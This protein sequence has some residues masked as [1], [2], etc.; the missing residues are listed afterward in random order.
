MPR[1][2]K[3]VPSYRLHKTSGQAVVTVYRPDGTPRDLLLGPFE[4]AASRAEYARVCAAL[5]PGSVYVEP[6]AETT[7]AEVILAF[8][9]HAQEYYSEGDEFRTFR[10]ALKV[11]RAVSGD[12]PAAEF[13]PLALK[14]VREAMVGKGWSRQY[15]N[16]QVG[17]VVRV[18]KWAVSEQLVPETV[19]RALTSVESLRA[20]KTA[21]P[22]SAARV[23]ADPAHVAAALPH[24]PP[25][26]RA[27]VELLRLTGMRPAEACR[28]TLG[29]IDRRGEVWVYAPAR[30][31]LAHLGRTRAVALGPAAQAVVV[32]HLG[33]AGLGPDDPLFSPARQQEQIA[34]AKRAKRKSKVQPSQVSRKKAK[35]AR[36]PGLWFTP[37]AV[38][39]AV[40]RACRKAQ[41]PAWSPY[42]LRHLVAAELREQFTLEH[43]RAAL[44]HSHASMSAHYA[45]GADLKLAGEVAGKVG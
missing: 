25:H 41:V 44:G 12:A 38:C 20:G 26:T 2:R 31:K 17:R 10:H 1:P 35:P 36:A 16:R 27:L 7:V 15:V 21:A 28:M 37:E 6:A 19:H 43:V 5:R 18:F 32:G 29:Q 42:Q 22:E 14:A 3:T 8:V 30:H 4:S 39:H 11:L 45:R 9:R 23:P 34:A 13:G 24:L 33:G 40:R